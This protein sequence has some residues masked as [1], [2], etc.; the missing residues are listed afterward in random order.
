MQKRDLIEVKSGKDYERH[1]ALSNL[2]GNPEYAISKAYVL[3]NGNLEHRGQII[4]APIYMTMFI[5]RRQALQSQI[6]RMDMTGL[7]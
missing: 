5:E 1:N 6:F 4:Y 3:C 7:R 2:M